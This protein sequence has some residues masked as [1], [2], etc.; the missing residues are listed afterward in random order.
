MYPD[1]SYLCHDLIGTQPDNW[2]SMLKTFGFFLAI[3]FIVSAVVFHIELKRKAREG[4]YTPSSESITIGLPASA[5]MSVTVGFA[6]IPTG[7]V[8]EPASWA[9]MIAGFS[10]VGTALRR[11]KVAHAA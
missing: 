11:R 8:S 6:S 10:M 9:L 3:A 7:G 4:F 5:R 1:L 2:L